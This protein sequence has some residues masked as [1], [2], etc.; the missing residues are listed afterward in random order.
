MNEYSHVLWDWN[1]TLLDDVWLCVDIVNAM[2]ARR[3]RPGIDL[4]RYKAIFDFPVR[5]YYERAG[6]D[7][8]REAFE[9]ACT[10]FCNEYARRVGECRL[11]D[12]TRTVLEGWAA[13]GIR[14]IVLSTTEQSRLEAMVAAFGIAHLF[15]DIVGQAD[16]YAAGKA[17]RA[18][19]LLA[20]LGIGGDRVLLI[21]DTTHD[22]DVAREIGVGCALV[23]AG[24]HTHEKLVR[25]GVR[26]VEHLSRIMPAWTSSVS[27]R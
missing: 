23:S 9:S 2:L 15:D 6:F 13:R 10:E 20:A 14:Q 19:A 26:V 24:H 4:Q 27:P 7:F 21:G 18:R 16:H 17:A 1:G 22:A 12:D 11:H 5:G 25:T 8:S 3:G